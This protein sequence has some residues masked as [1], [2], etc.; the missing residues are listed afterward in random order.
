MRLLNGLKKR[1][2]LSRE[3]QDYVNTKSFIRESSKKLGEEQI[4]SMF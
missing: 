4:I 1:Y 3:M 2:N